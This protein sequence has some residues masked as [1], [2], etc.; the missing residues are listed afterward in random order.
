MSIHYCS[1]SRIVCFKD[2]TH[3]LL[4]PLRKLGKSEDKSDWCDTAQNHD[5]INYSGK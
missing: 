5:T 3:I 1:T 2:S 4:L